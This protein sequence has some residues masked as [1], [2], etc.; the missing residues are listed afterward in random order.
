VSIVPLVK[1]TV[2]GHLKEKARVLEDLQEIG[3]L[4]LLPLTSAGAAVYERGPSADAHE[5]LKYLL[6][7]PNRRQ[8]VQ[9]ASSFGGMAVERRA[10]EIRDRT[11]TLEDE[12]DFLVARIKILQPW[13]DFRLRLVDQHG[14]RLWFYRVPYHRLKEV[15]ETDLIWEAVGRDNQFD[16]VAVISANEPQGM[17]VARSRTGSKPLSELEKRLKEVEAEL[18]EL[19]AERTNLTRW[20]DLFVASLDRLEDR[21]ALLDAFL[22]TYDESPLFALQGWA[23]KER[24]DELMQ[25]AADGRILIEVEE[26]TKEDEP[27]TLFRNPPAVQPGESLVEFY[28]TP[29]YRLWDPSGVVLFS[30]SIFFAMI[31]SDAGY[32]AVMGLLLVLGWKKMCASASGRRTRLMFAYLI[33]AS[34]GWG[35]LVGSYFGVSPAEGSWL[36]KLKILDVNDTPTMMKLS[37]IIGASHVAYSNLRDAWRQ[38]GSGVALAPAG[39]A[40]IVLGGLLIYLAIG[41]TGPAAFLQDAGIAV[42]AIGGSLTLLFTGAGQPVG[43]RLLSGVMSFTKVSTA[44]G[45]VLSYLRLF[46]LGLASASLAVAFNGL[47]RQVAEGL[48]GIGLFFALLI[49][50]IGHA[51]NFALAIVSGFV[52][53]LRLNLIEFFRWSISEEGRPFRAF[54]KKEVA[55]WTR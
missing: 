51:L 12:R 10:L 18:E 25:Y 32:A 27:P 29:N 8:Q 35:V 49:L 1:V 38:R 41:A 15:E 54:E 30:F 14:H 26:P 3:C 53:G 11:Q 28:Q 39:W 19:Q 50:L 44:F 55:K 31:I 4:H 37:I 45:D 24:T 48:P 36:A 42:M 33:G 23:S 13:G 16:Y 17:P 5:A 46:A 52:H 21:Q 6:S 22:E 47:A 40:A 9:D 7:C 20:C 43:K 34:V 2:C